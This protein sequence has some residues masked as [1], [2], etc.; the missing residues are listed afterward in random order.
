MLKLMS[1]IVI[2]GLCLACRSEDVH[3]RVRVIVPAEIPSIS[4][5]VLRMS[6]WAYDTRLADTPAFLV[7]A[8][9]LFFAHKA[10]ERDEAW[11]TVQGDLPSGTRHYI[12]VRGF[13]LVPNGEKYI[14]WDG[15]GGTEAPTTVVM[16]LVS[17]ALVAGSLH[18]P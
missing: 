6:L 17:S 14:L 3:L 10:G 8:D 11:M 15:I 2:A 16:R 18:Q 1:A 9:S 4:S 5:G 7:D 12:T 13:E